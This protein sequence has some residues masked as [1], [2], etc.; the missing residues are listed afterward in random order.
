[1]REH[2]EPQPRP[3]LFEEE[4][5][6]NVEHAGSVR[7]TH[8][9]VSRQ[10]CE[11]AVTST[12]GGRDPSLGQARR[13]TSCSTLQSSLVIAS[14]RRPLREIDLQARFEALYHD[15]ECRRTRREHAQREK[16]RQEEAD[17][18]EMRAQ[19]RPRL[20]RHSKWAADQA[21]THAR[22]LAD[23]KVQRQVEADRRSEESMR[24]CSFAPMIIRRSP[25]EHQLHKAQL[26][27]VGLAKGQRACLA[28]LKEVLEEERCLEATDAVPCRRVDNAA[29][30]QE[31][32][33]IEAALLVAR[34]DSAMA[35]RRF[36]ITR[37]QVFHEV[38]RLDAEA[39]NV[40]AHSGVGLEELLFSEPSPP[41]G[42]TREVVLFDP[43]LVSRLRGEAW[44]EDAMRCAPVVLPPPVP[45]PLAPAHAVPPQPP[46]L[47]LPPPIPVATAWASTA[48]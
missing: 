40:I 7:S 9:G 32:A 43:D 48:Q 4:N 20:A 15:G 45:V 16:S 28:R 26:A 25:R 1:V 34:S 11:E 41:L 3:P 44:Y 10:N 6:E 38:A 24:E 22:K 8:G 31:A 23:L 14:E 35:Q 42:R 19:A 30:Q 29:S 2:M 12:F 13:A 27:L 39:R 47:S 21:A 5:S 18:K 36:K 37:L 46:V 17:I 33:I